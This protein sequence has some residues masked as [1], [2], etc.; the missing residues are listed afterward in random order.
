MKFSDFLQPCNLISNRLMERSCLVTKLF[1]CFGRVK[2]I[3][4]GKVINHIFR[5]RWRRTFLLSLLF[6]NTCNERGKWKWKEEEWSF[7]TPFF[8]NDVCKFRISNDFICQNI[9][10]SG[11]SVFYGQD[12]CVCK[13]SYITWK[14][15]SR[16]ASSLRS[17]STISTSFGMY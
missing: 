4:S 15:F 1:S 5:K 16:D 8:R 2:G 9:A 14:K 13:V 11:F 7:A 6:Q 10:L 17:P 12:D 3:I